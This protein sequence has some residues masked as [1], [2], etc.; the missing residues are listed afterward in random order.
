MCHDASFNVLHHVFVENTNP[1]SI[2]VLM[3]GHIVKEFQNL[4]VFSNNKFV[5]MDELVHDL[6]SALEETARSTK[7]QSREGQPSG[8]SSKRCSRKRKGKKRRTFIVDGGNISEA[9]ESSVEEA[10]KDYMENIIQQ[11]DSDDIGMSSTV[12]RLT[13][14]LNF[15]YVPSVESDSVTET[16]SPRRPQ[17]RRK[18]YKSMAVDN[19]PEMMMQPPMHPPKP[20]QHHHGSDG[21]LNN[22]SVDQEATLAPL[23]SKDNNGLLVSVLP[24]K[25]KRSS[26]SR[27]DFPSSSSSSQSKPSKNEDT[28]DVGSQESSSSLSSSESDGLITNDEGREADDEQSDFFYEGGPACGIPG[29]IPWWENDAGHREVES[30]KEFQQI[31][32]GTFE[33]LSKSSQMAFKARVSRLMAKSGREIRFGRR[34]LKEKHP[35]YTV[36]RFLQDRQVWNSMQG[37]ISPAWQSSNNTSSCNDNSKRRRNTPPPTPQTEGFIGNEAEPIPDS[38]L[39]SK[40]LQNMGWTPGSGLG[41]DGAGIKT[42]VMAYRRPRR[43][44]LGCRTATKPSDH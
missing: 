17:R 10:L 39:G 43:Q 30:D 20:Y 2:L 7:S 33:H 9:S 11:S 35:G 38:N 25:R 23:T 44:G 18:K 34:K 21:A 16:F 37:M 32:T 19:D 5:R 1:M 4:R 27:T 24:G 13:M 22:S 8:S 42:P 26:K 40:M 6:A 12:A 15:S 14:P 3:E 29:I 28:M 41:S 36:S 31:L